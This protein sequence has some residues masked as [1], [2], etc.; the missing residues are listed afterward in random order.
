MPVYPA[1]AGEAIKLPVQTAQ[2]KATAWLHLVFCGAVHYLLQGTES[3]PIIRQLFQ[4]HTQSSIECLH[5]P[6]TSRRN[7]PI[8]DLQVGVGVC[9]LSKTWWNEGGCT[10]DKVM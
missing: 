2:P 9:M 10:L 1:P 3:E 6:C 8:M 7:E 4:G 5:V